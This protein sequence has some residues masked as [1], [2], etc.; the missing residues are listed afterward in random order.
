M[1]KMNNQYQIKGMMVSMAILFVSCVM[2]GCISI[3]S[4]YPE[5]GKPDDT[6]VI[7]GSGF[8]S[9]VSQNTVKF[10]GVPATVLSVP[11]S[12]KK[13]LTSVPAGVKTGMISVTNTSN[14]Q[15][16]VSKN[17]FIYPGDAKWTFL[18]YLDADNN[19]EPDGL[20]DFIE[21]ASVG[22][23][24]DIHIVVQMDR[25]GY[26]SA[27]GGWKNTRRFMIQKNNT[28][29]VTPVQD[30]GELNMGDPAVLQDFVEW[31]ITHYPAQRYA[32]VLWNHGGGWRERMDL[33][34]QRVSNMRGSR[35]QYTESD[36]LKAVC[37]DETSGD[38]P[39]YMY[40]LKQALT[41][42]KASVDART[43]TS[44]KLDLVGFDACLMGMI[45]VAYELRDLTGYMVGSEDTEPGAG[46]P[47]NTILTQLSSSPSMSP[48]DLAGMIV[49]KYYSSYPASSA[50]T[51]SALDLSKLSALVTAIDDFTGKANTEWANLK[52]ARASAK[53]FHPIAG[54]NSFWGVDIVD[55]F[56]KIQ[57]QVASTDIKTACANVQNASRQAVISE[58][59]G[60]GD[61]GS[62]GLAIY[63]PKTKTDYDHDVDYPGYEQTNT[64]M[65]VDYVHQHLWSGWLK[66]YYTNNP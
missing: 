5:T 50:T 11:V 33:V 28:P 21:M 61:N 25:G 2:N 60:T 23:S 34:T 54:Y 20:D 65:P 36:A 4:F 49:Q 10:A 30:M 35:A 7:E 48:S 37:W 57:V 43:G 3:H 55:L 15:T 42:A 32:L 53:Q 45:E 63:F 9:T 12:G 17:N 22:S 39:L 8:G 19:L 62:N 6:V 41:G 64:T 40:E 13:L 47:Y 31:G 46:W 18:V 51:Q 58:L 24:K 16:A 26:S 52:T 14:N 27:Y 59:H 38:D 56:G 66:N 29:S 44:T 1:F